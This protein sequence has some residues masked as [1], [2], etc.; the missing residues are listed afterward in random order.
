MDEVS[1]FLSVVKTRSRCLISTR[2]WQL[3]YFFIFTTKIGEDEPQFDSYFSDGLKPQP[4]TSLTLAKFLSLRPRRIPIW[5][6]RP[7]TPGR[8]GCQH[9]LRYHPFGEALDGHWYDGGHGRTPAPKLRKSGDRLG[10]SPLSFFYNIFFSA[11]IC[12]VFV[13]CESCRCRKENPWLQQKQE[14]KEAET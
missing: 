9:R 13:T 4:P 2:L 10:F 7:N 8:F 6:R 5:I 1:T 3:K 11:M 12:N 14:E